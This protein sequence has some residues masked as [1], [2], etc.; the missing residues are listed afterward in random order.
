MAFVKS[1]D[2]RRFKGKQADHLGSLDPGQ[3]DGP[4]D[5]QVNSARKAFLTKPPRTAP[6]T[7]PRNTQTLIKNDCGGVILTQHHVLTAAH[8][9]FHIIH[10][11][12]VFGGTII[13]RASLV[14]IRIGSTYYDRG[15]SEYVTSKTVVHE[16][17][18]YSKSKD[19]DV[20]VLVL[21]TSISNY[22]SSSVQPAVIPPG[23]YVVP[24]NASV[25]VVGWGLADMGSKSHPRGLRHVGLRTVDRDTC[26]ARW[27]QVVP[28]LPDSML[29]A[30]LLG[31]GGAGPC[32]G[33]SGGPLVYNGV[34]VGVTSFSRRCDDPF[35]PHVFT[36]VASYTAWINNIVRQNRV[37]PKRSPNSAA[38]AHVDFGLML[39][40]SVWIIYSK[41]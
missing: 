30:G 1:T 19:N 20:A 10:Y 13:L 16:D 21:P 39:L 9:L 6:P 38:A 2:Y 37:Q 29:C 40:A 34:V 36:R 15:G 32:D 7:T 27:R 5:A 12:S 8:C 33:D 14:T 23:G 17:F 28:E 24:D 18:N 31:V 26:G 11:L 41:N 22:R 3:P 25:V 35:Y 4:S